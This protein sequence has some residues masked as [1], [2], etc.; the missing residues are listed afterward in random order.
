MQNIE[1]LYKHSLLTIV[2]LLI[3]SIFFSCEKKDEMAPKVIINQPAGGVFVVMDTI[4]ISANVSDNEKI[5]T[6]S[7][8]L[9]DENNR[10]VVPSNT[11][12]PNSRN[13]NLDA[14]FI[15]DNLYLE[16]GKYYLIVEA[17]DEYNSKKAYVSIQVGALER[18]LNSI[19]V[20]EKQ[21]SETKLF[22]IISHQKNL[23]R[24]FPYPYQDF[25]FNP[26]S[27]QYQFLTEEGIL[28][29]FSQKNPKEEPLWA[30]TDLKDPTRPYFGTLMYFNNSTK[31]SSYKGEIRSYNASGKLINTASSN[32]N[33]GH[34]RQYYYDYNKIMLIKEPFMQGNDKIERLNQATGA[35][36]I[37]YDILFSP[38]KL[39]FVNEDLAVVFGNKNNIA[40]ACSLSTVYNVVNYFGNFGE[41]KLGDAFKYS[42]YI[43]LISLDNKI[44]EY[45]LA[46]GY[47]RI[48]VSTNSNVQFYYEALSQSI[49]YIDG[50]LVNKLNY[51]AEGSTVYFSNNR[52]I[53]DMHF[54]Y[55]K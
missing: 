41:K 4:R 44:I 42:E 17:K 22:S 40:K 23:I 16:S 37:A 20:V 46:N 25:L 29:A 34:I 3:I 8:H 53:D 1:S 26:Y 49:Y 45:D 55:N 30:V 47:Q 32:D 10:R 14:L 48:L 38:E 43:Y 6:V 27:S 31:V 7:V 18:V 11:Y 5:T 35:S 12:F 54:V 21:T 9:F 50:S 28:Y 19:L 36:L 39:L 24:T 2:S 52:T 13:Y 51:P 33:T 15:I